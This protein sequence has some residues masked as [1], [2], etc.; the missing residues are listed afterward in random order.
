MQV[1]K[2]IIIVL[3]LLASMVG[4]IL[5]SG[6][7]AANNTGGADHTHELVLVEAKDPTCA[8]PGYRK[9]YS[10][11]GCEAIFADAT[12]FAKLDMATV[13]IAPLGHNV[14]ATGCNEPKYCATCN[15]VVAEAPG[16]IAAVDAAVEATC[17]VNGKTEGSHC[18][19][20]GEVL[21]PQVTVGAVG[22]AYDNKSD[23]ECNECGYTRGEDECPHMSE[24]LTPSVT[25]PTCTEEGYTTYVC[26]CNYY[27]VADHVPAT[28]HNEVA[29]AA[30]AP[31]CLAT[32]LGE[33]SH[34]SEC[35]IVI[36]KQATVAAKGVHTWN[37]LTCTECGAIRFEAEGADIVFEMPAGETKVVSTG[38]E[39]KTPAETNYPS[40]DSFVYFMSYSDTTTLTF[41]V[42]ASKA[43]KATVSVRMGCAT[44]AAMLDD[45]FYVEV[46]GVK[47]ENRPD[48]I[49]PKWESSSAHP[50]YYDWLEL[51]ISDI[52][53]NAGANIIKVIKPY[54]DADDKD[55]YTSTH[56][57]NFD[58]MAIT[59]EDP[60][61]TLQD[62]RDAN[63]HVNSVVDIGTY[64][65]YQ[66]GGELRV[67]CEN[68]RLYEVITLP[69]I[70]TE[71][72]TKISG[73]TFSSVWQYTHGD[74]TFEFTVA[75]I[76]QKYTFMGNTDADPFVSKNGGG[77]KD[78]NGAAV[79][80]TTEDAANGKYYYANAN[81]NSRY[82]TMT[83]YVEQATTIKFY[84][85]AA[86]NNKTL[87]PN[88]ILQNLKVNGSNT[89]VTYSTSSIKWSNNSP[90]NW[91]IF[92]ECY[93]ATIDLQAGENTITFEVIN[94]S[95]NLDRVVI[96]SSVP[97]A[98]KKVA[99]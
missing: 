34:C 46:N 11:K 64:P 59:P 57:L 33:G 75:E 21:V 84:V 23:F 93:I 97:V 7:L 31:G 36:V 48:V 12:G 85:G 79:E 41:Y 73:D 17:T 50:K 15:Q 91:Y 55:P 67:Y 68:C 5:G 70:S 61:M 38:R 29:D 99:E 80:I 14:N 63:G 27:Y 49:F 88:K 60:S 6:Y 69:K 96:E 3:V 43:G 65:S 89:G 25:P 66:A 30:V 44:S 16:H 81:E 71:N 40:G 92:N 39:G 76:T 35:N 58:Y 18:S 2:V 45:L 94:T 53:L 78:A 56:G 9:H 26:S 51:E 52:E 62:T 86:K 37:G 54:P 72:Y 8:D 83:I 98:L 20:C 13:T 77:V 32:G 87:A 47:Y 42:T 24:D 74:Q 82:Y 1:I 22:H 10:C 95:L 4:V 19:V 90:A 28:G